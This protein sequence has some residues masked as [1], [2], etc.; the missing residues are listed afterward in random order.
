VHGDVL[1]FNKAIIEATLPYA[2]AYK[3][4]LAFYE[5]QGL[6]GWR[7]LEESLALIPEGYLTIAD[8]K[9]GDIGN[10]AR[11]YAQAFFEQ[12]NFDAITVAPYMGH[13]SILPFL[14][15]P[16]KWVFLLGLTSNAGA[17]DFQLLNVQGQPLYQRVMQLAASWLH[18]GQLGYVVGATRPEQLAELRGLYPAAWFLV[19]GVGA[20]GGDL[21][22][23]MQAGWGQQA[24]ILVNS[25]RGILYA[26][27]GPD[28]AEAAAREA[29][30]LQLQMEALL[31]QHV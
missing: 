6:A 28:Y 24:G 3:F 16:G 15:Y 8:A 9:R 27:S 18:A 30:Q 12:L 7:A 10:T 19:P 23:V 29:Q 21:Q 20:Q 31:R 13:D 1:A 17:A 2:L 14:D 26:S 25:S 22:A 5:A 11:R 4:N